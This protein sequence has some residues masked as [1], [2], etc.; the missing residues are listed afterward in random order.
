M[1][2]MIRSMI[3]RIVQERSGGNPI[4]VNTVKTK[5][6]LKGIQPDAYTA[7]SPD[8]AQVMKKVRAIGAELGVRV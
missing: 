6:I 3:D 8:E 1:A 5:L 4:L 7:N 2:G